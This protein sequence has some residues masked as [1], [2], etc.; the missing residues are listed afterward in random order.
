MSLARALDAENAEAFLG[1]I[2]SCS[3]CGA[4]QCNV[5]LGRKLLCHIVGNS[6]T[7]PSKTLA[8][9][10]D[11]YDLHNCRPSYAQKCVT[12]HACTGY[13]GA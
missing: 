5:V 7:T 9:H 1:L 13:V 2:S 3:I 6:S 8:E 12:Q 4:N 10:R 11:D